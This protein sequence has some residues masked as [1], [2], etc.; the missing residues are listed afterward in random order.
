MNTV[1]RRFGISTLTSL[2]LFSRAPCTRIRSWLS[3]TCGADDCV[4]VLVA[5]LIVSPSPRRGR[6]RGLRRRRLARSDGFR[7][8]RL[9]LLRRRG[10]GN[11]PPSTRRRCRPGCCDA[12][13][14][15]AGRGRA[16]RRN[17]GILRRFRPGSLAA[18]T[19]RAR[20]EQWERRWAGR[21]AGTGLGEAMWRPRAGERV[22]WS[23][24]SSRRTISPLPRGRGECPEAASRRSVASAT[25][26]GVAGAG[27]GRLHSREWTASRVATRSFSSSSSGRACSSPASS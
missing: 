18:V 19:R 27:Y 9:A 17:P 11:G 23:A 13:P 3:A 15:C 24:W 5:M 14:A 22:P 8:A 25:G 1:S 26:S 6:L 7:A 12:R 2:R 21:G 10:R 16:R 4:S 20:L